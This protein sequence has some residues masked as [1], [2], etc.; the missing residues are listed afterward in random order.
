MSSAA[1][2]ISRALSTLTPLIIIPLL[3]IALI[4]RSVTALVVTLEVILLL[5]TAWYT[6]IRIRRNVPSDVLHEYASLPKRGVLLGFQL[7][8]FILIIA[9]V[10]LSGAYSILPV[11][12]ALIIGLYFLLFLEAYYFEIKIHL[13]MVKLIIAQ[14]LTYET[15][16]FLYQS[17]FSVDSFR[18]YFIASSIVQHGG[19]V[20]QAYT[21]NIW[22]NF[23]P[24][25]PL[26][27][28]IQSLITGAPL[29][30]TELVSGFVFASLS[31][32][33][34]GALASKIFK[35]LRITALTMLISSLVPFFWQFAT[36]PLP[37]LFALP[38]VLLAVGLVLNPSSGKAILVTSLFGVVIVF[39]HGGMA[40]LLIATTLAVFGLTRNIRALQT[41]VIASILFGA[42]SILA[43]VNGTVSGVTTIS[44]FVSSILSP[45]TL[46]VVF[47]LSSLPTGA[48]I[49][50]AQVLTATE[51][52]VFLGIISWIGFLELAQRSRNRDF[53]TFV[54][55]A[56]VLFG[57]GVLLLFQPVVQGQ[58]GRYVAL[59]S[60]V[61]LSIPASF[62]LYTIGA[63][64]LARRVLVPAIILVMIGASVCN[65]SVSPGVWQ[66]LGA[67][68]Y[69]SRI[70][71]TQTTSEALSQSY[72][73]QYDSCYT[74]A[75]NYYPNFVNLTSSCSPARDFQIS[76]ETNFNG[77]GVASN[78]ALPTNG[79]SYPKL[80]APFVV[81]F[82]TRLQEYYPGGLADPQAN[83]SA[84]ATDVVFTDGVSLVGFVTG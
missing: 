56:F 40:L 48:A 32:I 13:F 11:F 8:L 62:A 18:D 64:P 57:V 51:W 22:Y 5:L 25:A 83:M 78:S 43:S 42:Y 45:G 44:R 31:T 49:E 14:V 36:L 66:D 39:T 61:V 20:P 37:E 71:S 59:L 28:A 60:Y 68:T 27:Y 38:L 6:Y 84:P 7:G 3:T 33:A 16:A 21:S 41:G 24:M 79:I 26:T 29:L 19:G 58:A 72:L 50:V 73:N 69:S 63:N 54:L 17:V 81:L 9:S 76:S 77:F 55:V 65:S 47:T 82:S 53:L 80:V 30:Q 74:I 46:H 70:L 1:A 34:A 12:F 15:F 52:W 67:K 10:A 23:T 35:N 4:Y 75:A 2:R